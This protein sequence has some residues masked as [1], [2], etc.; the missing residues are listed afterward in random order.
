M[1]FNQ[2]EWQLLGPMQRTEYH[3]V[4]LETLGNLVSVGKTMLTFRMPQGPLRT[5]TLS[6]YPLSGLA[7]LSRVSYSVQNLYLGL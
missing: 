2:E 3:D 4:M 1:D 7:V 5:R 6:L